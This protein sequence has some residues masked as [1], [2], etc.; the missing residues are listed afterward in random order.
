MNT[1]TLFCIFILLAF[2]CNPSD[3][4]SQEQ[5]PTGDA[6]LR[7]CKLNTAQHLW[8]GASIHFK[9][10]R[11][12]EPGL[13][14]QIIGQ[15][16]AYFRVLVPDGYFCYI[17]ADYLNVDTENNGTVTGNGVAL[18]S[19]PNKEGD[20]PLIRVNEGL[21]VLVW[22]RVG[23]WYRIT[24]PEIAHVYVLMSEVTEIE[25]NPALMKEVE[26]L[27]ATR[28]ANWN[29]HMGAIQI[30]FQENLKARAIQDRFNALESAAGTGYKGMNLEKTAADYEEIS[31]TSPNEI[32]RKIAEVRI[33]EIKALIT[34]NKALEQLNKREVT[35]RKERDKLEKDLKE[36][37]T[38]KK[39]AEASTH[40][41][42]GKGVKV[43][44]KG[45]MATTGAGAVLKGGK[46][47]DD[48]LYRI[49]CPDGRFILGDFLGKRIL[50]QGRL[51]T[52]QVGD[53]PS[54]IIV[55]RLEFDMNSIDKKA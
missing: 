40:K 6:K 47:Q 30:E 51:D 54:L 32:T 15:K 5:D 28:M 43:T 45:T 29:S 26:A 36:T 27:R 12:V 8:S 33:S 9:K 13:L 44:V 10:V 55:E 18:R 19:I 34:K 20:Y 17:N 31:K 49:S 11:H 24:A 48:I 25:V 35:W 41:K 1:K 23:E 39:K 37:D 22:N 38:S 14:L 21:K 3:L 7:Y 4:F 46:N 42:T 52:N 50:I 16:N 53:E 2:F